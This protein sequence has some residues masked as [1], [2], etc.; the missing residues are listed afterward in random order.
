MTIARCIGVLIALGFMG[1]SAII[2]WRYGARL[3]RDAVDQMLFSAVS[4]CTD[5]AKSATPFFFFAAATHRRIAH[6]VTAAVFWFACTSYSLVSIGGF[7]EASRAAQTGALSGQQT[8]YATVSA[9][10]TRKKMERDAIGVVLSPFVTSA[11]LSQLSQDR[12]WESSKRCGE[13][14]NAGERKFC[15]E[16]T[17]AEVAHARSSS[18]EVLDHRLRELTVELAS[19]GGAV[20]TEHGDPRVSFLTRLSGGNARAAEVVLMILFLSVVEIGSGLGLFIA[21]GHGALATARNRDGLCRSEPDMASLG[22]AQQGATGHSEL[23]DRG[24]GVENSG[25]RR[26]GVAKFARARLI[27]ATGNSVAIDELFVAYARWCRN[28][29]AA[30]LDADAFAQCFAALGREV[31][32]ETSA[33]GRYLNLAVSGR[34]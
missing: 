17:A 30:A 6:A 4:L 25:A 3:G 9:E 2:N 27:A 16:L 24:R 32:F 7:M 21:V 26:G 11:R 28:E 20:A 19:L 5:I 8:T 14:R 33:E 18:A 29:K 12:R 31:G 13:V 10:F 23:D 1:L 22:V 15:S 34:T